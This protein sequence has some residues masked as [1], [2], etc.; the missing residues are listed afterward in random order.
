MTS[1]VQ[2]TAALGGGWD[3]TEVPTEKEVARKQ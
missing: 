2:L 1:A 3:A